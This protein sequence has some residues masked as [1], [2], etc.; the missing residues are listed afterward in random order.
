MVSRFMRFILTMNLPYTRVHGGANRSNRA[1]CEALFQSG[2]EVHV[3]VPALATPSPVTREQVLRELDEQGVSVVSKNGVDLFTIDGVEVHAVEDPSKLRLYIAEQLQ[4]IKPDWAFVSSEDPSQTILATALKHCPGR[5]IYLA[6]SPPLF[7]FGPASL[8]PSDSRTQLVRQAAAVVP[9]SKWAAEYIERWSGIKATPIHFP[10][11]GTGPFPYLGKLENPFVLFMNASVIKGL[12]IFLEIARALPEVKF[13]ALPGY[14]TTSSD[15]EVL[16]GLHNVTLLENRRNL[17]DIFKLTSIVLMPSLWLESFGMAAVDSMLRGIPVLSSDFGGLLEA[18][19]GTDYLLPVNPIERFEERLGENMLPVPIVPAQDIAPWIDALHGL[20]SD[21]A[22]YEWQSNAVREV[23]TRFVSGLSVAPLE[24]LLNDLMSKP[25]GTGVTTSQDTTWKSTTMSDGLEHLTPQQQALLVE[26][27]KKKA[28]SRANKEENGPPPLLIPLCSRERTLPLSFAQ[29]RLWFLQKLAPDA[30]TYNI[31]VAFRVTGDLDADALERSLQCI[32]NRHEILR[33]TFTIDTGEARQCIGPELRVAIPLTDLSALPEELR[34]AELQRLWDAEATTPFDLSEGPI[35]RA[36]LL[37]LEKRD[38]VFMLTIH[39]VASDAWSMGVLFRELSTLYKAFI[40]AQEAS[41]PPL[42]IQYADYAVWQREWVAGDMLEEQLSYWKEHLKGIPALSELPTD[43]ARPAVQ[44][45]RGALERFTLPEDLTP[46]LLGLAKS[47]NVTPFMLLLSFFAILLSRWSGQDDVAIGTPSAGRTHSETD[48]L[49]GFFVNTLVLRC[50]LSGAPTFADLA[51]RVREVCLGAYSHQ[52]VPFEK[53]VNELQVQRTLDRNPLFQVMFSY[54]EHSEPELL[55]GD[56]TAKVQLY[57]SNT[58]KFDLTLGITNIQGRLD[59][60][61]EYNTDIFE[62]ST[63]RRFFESFQTLLSS[64]MMSPETLITNLD[65]LP[66][67]EQSQVL[68]GFNDN[69][70]TYPQDTCVHYIIEEQ[71]ARTPN[72]TA[73]V[74]NGRELT[75]AELN[76]RSN[77]L[78]RHLRAIGV[79]PGV[80]VGICVERSFEMVVGL[81]GILKAGGAYVPVDPAYPE[82]RIAFMLSDASAAVLLAQEKFLAKLGRHHGQ[83][84]CLDTQWSLIGG[85]DSENLGQI[86]STDDIAYVIYTSGSTG[87]PK[88][89]GVLHRG[90]TNL[91]CWYATEFQIGNYDRILLV[92]SFGFDLTQKNIL[93]PLT[94]GACLFLFPFEHYD[95]D[96]I[97]HAISTHQ[98]TLLNCTPSAFYPLVGSLFHNSIDC[99]SSIRLLILGGE[100]IDASRLSLWTK[101]PGFQAKVVNTYG[102]TE[103][104][105]VVAFHVATAQELT[106]ERPIPLGRPIP[107]SRLFVLDKHLQPTPIGVPG[108][109]CISGDCVGTGYVNRPELTLERFLSDPFSNDPDCRL[110]KTGDL[111]R[112]RSDGKLEFLGRLD[113]QVKIRGVRIELEEI[114]SSLRNVTGICDAVAT[115]DED[116]TR[117]KLLVA[118]V[119]RDLVDEDWNGEARR[120]DYL[121][122]YLKFQLPQH[123]LPS[124]IIEISSIPLTPNGKVDKGRLPA[125]TDVSL[126]VSKNQNAYLSEFE[127]A[128]T[129]ICADFLSMPRVGLQDN[130][131][132]LGG[133]SFLATRFI[134]EIQRLFPCDEQLLAMFYQRPTVQMLASAI[135]ENAGDVD[136]E[137][138]A[139]TVRLVRSLSDDE[140]AST[141][142]QL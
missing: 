8:Y 2:H 72:A 27:L 104:T 24:E 140:V 82:E 134:F 94:T 70:G 115:V 69:A 93:S 66:H 59:C 102:P 142:S 28:A 54:D 49:I 114:E 137:G 44:S 50:D 33:T 57:H 13:A 43:Y 41:L 21:N 6:H 64:T 120:A 78:A 55:L 5:V 88:G 127:T 22:L 124:H 98:I 117:N 101:S 81:L 39:H 62:A 83:I 96:L 141:L 75:Y 84:I 38:H 108:E 9:I 20:L 89:S 63:I 32:V 136:I 131:F 40:S 119:V 53:L 138:I 67:A 68:F 132:Y 14:G 29:Q 100:T 97:A 91:V 25:L 128:L 46:S 139:K 103:C 42:R 86:A 60:V 51:G 116:A 129:E 15:K 45:Y 3:I 37:R 12:P 11:Y 31:P 85:K 126:S 80:L 90:L 118:Y 30:C 112:W 109:L 48:G 7:P 17:D 35:V 18:K 106:G 123:M 107:N 10:H 113:N 135:L 77:Q 26:V 4:E 130:F 125:L 111:A 79:G 58:S 16:A 76:A 92:S 133:H 121:R 105:D 47:L 110:Y 122:D 61:F 1:L 95:P 74:F 71:A 34:I 65:I 23:A 36:S 19:L 99:L 52:D 73:V 56:C 87:R